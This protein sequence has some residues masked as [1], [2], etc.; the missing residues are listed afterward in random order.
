MPTNPNRGVY[1]WVWDAGALSW[2]RQTSGGGGGDATAANQATGNASLASIDSKLD[3]VPS[4]LC[5]SAGVGNP[6]GTTLTP[7]YKLY[8]ALHDASGNGINSDGSGG[9][10]VNLISANGLLDI[11]THKGDVYGSDLYVGTGNGTPVNQP[12]GSSLKS[13][14]MVVTGSGA[15]ATTWDVRL[16]GSIDSTNYSQILQHTNATGDG[17]TVFSG[18]VLSPCR[19]FRSRCA[20]LT[21]GG[22]SDIIVQI[23]G[24]Q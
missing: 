13:F 2:I 1:N 16:E 19:F 8:V 5:D 6:I 23:L 22:A 12:N 17:A 11:A 3:F 15:A 24:M 9:L 14:S 7:G 10:A 21:L 20:G 4:F 18:A